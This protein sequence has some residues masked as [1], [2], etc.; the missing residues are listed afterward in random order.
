[1]LN[2][3]NYCSTRDCIAI[4]VAFILIIELLDA[5]QPKDPNQVSLRVYRM[6]S[7]VDEDMKDRQDICVVVTLKTQTARGSLSHVESA[8]E[9]E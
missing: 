8:G 1:M 5:Q 9:R 2:S 6:S 7:E 4:D 3:R